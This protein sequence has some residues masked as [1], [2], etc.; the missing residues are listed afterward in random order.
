MKSYLSQRTQ[1]FQV[2]KAISEEA[3]ISGNVPQ[4]GSLSAILF[5]IYINDLLKAENES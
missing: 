4:G 3:P 2:D 1:R 5:S